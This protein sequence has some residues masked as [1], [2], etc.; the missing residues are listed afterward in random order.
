M[1]AL[2]SISPAPMDL[3]LLK[4]KV[5]IE[6]EPWRDYDTYFYD[7]SF[8]YT[9]SF[10]TEPSTEYTITILPGMEDRYGNTITEGMVVNYTTA[11]YPPELTLQTPGRCRPLQRV[12]P[13]DAR[14][15]RLTATSRGSICACGMSRCPSLATLTGP[16]NYDAWRSVQP[17][18]RRSTAAVVD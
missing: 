18:P 5:I 14:I 7:Y 6:P 13:D 12:Q 9:L 2:R 8:S 17:A 3:D 11:P 16:D 10:D 15:R 1:A 4:D